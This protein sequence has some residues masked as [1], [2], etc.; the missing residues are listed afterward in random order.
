MAQ[1]LSALVELDHMIGGWSETVSN[2]LIAARYL[3]ETR[4]GRGLPVRLM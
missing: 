3:A 4:H 1:W 2:V